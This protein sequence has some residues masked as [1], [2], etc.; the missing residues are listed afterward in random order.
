MRTY[1]VE[2]GY[3]DPTLEVNGTLY[4]SSR[5]IPPF[6]PDDSDRPNQ[7]YDARIVD[8]GNFTRQMFSGQSLFTQSQGNGGV[9]ILANADGE[10]DYLFQ[11]IFNGRTLRILLASDTPMYWSSYNTVML[12]TIDQASFSFS[13]SQ[14]SQIL[15]RIRDRKTLL[16]K[17]IQTI[18]FLGDNA[19]PDGVEGVE[20]D[21]KGKPKPKCFGECFNV[22]PPLVNTSKLIFQVHD[23]LIEEIVTVYDKGVALTKGDSIG[24]LA[25]LLT[26]TPASG[27]WDYYLG[28]ASDGAYFRLGSS[29]SGHITSDVKGDKFGGTYR[30]SVGDIIK[31]IAGRFGAISQFDEGAFG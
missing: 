8:P 25:T 5:R 1:L 27:E 10:L 9:V 14:P 24:S 30:T 16:D 12:G 3:Y 19:L 20:D 21:L 29:P 22:S 4:T 26:T 15:F 28:S 31:T 6:P 23:G 17:P 2:V 7:V 18:S 13:S 11:Y